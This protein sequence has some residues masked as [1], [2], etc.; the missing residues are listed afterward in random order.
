[1]SP[2]S[3]ELLDRAREG[4]ASA[5]DQLAAVHAETAISTAYYAT[6]YAARA[7]LSE[8]DLTARTH[9]GTWHLFDEAF[10]ATGAFDRELARRARAAQARREAS[11]YAAERLELSEAEELVEVARRFVDAV[12]RMLE[13]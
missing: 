2:R 1:M 6:L 13:A 4:V 5:R 3:D 9:A 11:D 12:A 7:A 10:V 8:R